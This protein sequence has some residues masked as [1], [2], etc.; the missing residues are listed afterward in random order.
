MSN[1]KVFCVFYHQ[2]LTVYGGVEI[3]MHALLFSALDGG[4][5]PG[6][7]PGTN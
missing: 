1:D 6:F 3:K 5:R 7:R 4:K 2:A